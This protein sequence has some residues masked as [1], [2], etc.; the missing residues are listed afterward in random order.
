MEPGAA[1]FSLTKAADGYVLTSFDQMRMRFSAAGDL[2]AVLDRNGQGVRVERSDGRVSEVANGRRSLKYAYNDDGLI[3]S[4]TLLAPATEPRSVN[5]AYT[6]GR[7]TSVTSPGGSKTTY[8]YD[9]GGRLATQFQGSATKPSLTTEYDADGRVISQTDAKGGK[10]S[11]LWEPAGI[12]GTSTMTDPVGGK[13][14]NE[15]ERNWL[16]RQVDPTGA[17]VTFHYDSSGNLIRVFD[18]LGHGARHVYDAHG[19]RTASTDA[20]GNVTRYSYS[21][22]NDLVATTDP[23]GRRTT[24]TYDPKGNLTGTAFAGSASTV[25]YDN[26]GLVTAVRDPLGRVTRLTYSADGDLL[27]VSDPAGRVTTQEVD[28][29]GR[30]TKTTSPRGQSTSYVYSADSQLLE[31]RGPLGITTKQTYDERGRLTSVTDPRGGASQFRYDDA[32]QLVGVKGPDPSLP[33]VVAEYDAA[34]RVTK[35]TDASGRSQAFEYDG[36]GRT[37]ATTYGNRTWR[38]GFDKAGRLTRTTLPS[39]KTASFTLDARGAMTKLEYSDKTVPVSF[40]WDAVGR[41][42]AMIDALG[43]TRFGYDSFDRLSSVT[44]PGA[45]IAYQWDRAGNLAA[46]TAAGHTESYTWDQVDRLSSA[47]VDGK[48]L[49]SYSYDLARGSVT[50]KRPSGLTETRLYDA[51]ER[52]TSLKLTQAGKTVREVSSEYD[53]AGNL[54]RSKDSVSGLVAYSYDPLSRLTEVCYAVDKC[55]DDA[56][57]YLR[58]AYDGAGNRTWENRPTGSTWS[59]YGPGSELLASITAPKEYPRAP[60]SARS[61]SYDAD[62]NL[63]SDGTIAFA[64]NAAGKPTSSTTDKATTTYTH[65]GDGRRASSTSGS[66]TTTYLWDALSPQILQTASGKTAQRYS[67]GAGLIAQSSAGGTS[68]LLSGR[69]GS[70]VAAAGKSLNHYDYEPYGAPRQA[71]SAAPKPAGPTYAGALQLPNGNY[72]MGQ[73]EYNPTTATFLSPDQGGS[74]QPYAYAAGNPISNNDLQ[75]L[76]DIE[77]TL[78]DVSTV[79]GWTSTAALT[80]AVT[81][82]IVRYCAPAVPMFLQVS[83]ATGMFSAG[84]AGVL[85][86]KACVVKG[87]C[88]A[89]A[90]DIAIGA[91]A[92]RFPALGRAA[93]GATSSQ[94]AT[95]ST[96]MVR[97]ADFANDRTAFRHYSKHVQGVILKPKGKYGL[98]KTGDEYAGDLPEFRG[99]A[100][101]RQNARLFMGGGAQPGSIEGIRPSD[102]AIIRVDPVSGYFG[103][104]SRSG[105]IITFFRPDGDPMDYYWSQY[106][107]N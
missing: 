88:S 20:A 32:D 74:T 42:T 66:R 68:E 100:E 85:D 87:N 56:T 83:A 14:V 38:F 35:H 9:G 36:A 17:A 18:G 103:V 72:L 16:V 101:Y 99:F 92:S 44:R 76:S 81:C 54:V 98:K 2:L 21:A 73:R 13:W 37:T 75:G 43:T 41:R 34:G 49:A 65:T 15:Y 47:K 70:L 59:L 55:S 86:S 89:L 67:Y 51:L 93:R 60:P 57:D 48:T 105:S 52:E 96:D 94:S 23:I 102:G 53:A 6:E 61:Y 28:G 27:R 8:G 39:G 31:Q 19:R 91:V 79:S 58:Y 80:G 4:V 10:T 3:S 95:A 82:T 46:R 90:A 24:F 25:S 78:T 22:S 104:R 29:W 45:T 1:R 77:G 11:W 62:G 64:W 106:G 97:V 30:P 33:E 69:A 63:A 7:L 50:V 26:R 40:A 12:R 5:Y 107:H 84:T 71:T